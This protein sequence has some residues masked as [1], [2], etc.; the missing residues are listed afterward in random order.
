MNTFQF[1]F[2]SLFQIV[3]VETI[4]NGIPENKMKHSSNV[5]KRQIKAHLIQT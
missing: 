1:T 5:R 2:D 3:F 4:D